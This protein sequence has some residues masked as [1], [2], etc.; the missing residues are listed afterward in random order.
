LQSGLVHLGRAMLPGFLRTSGS[1]FELDAAISL[2]P[3]EHLFAQTSRPRAVLAMR[4]FAADAL[5]ACF[6][7]GVESLPERVCGYGCPAPRFRCAGFGDSFL[8]TFSFL[9]PLL[10]TFS[11]LFPFFPPSF[12]SPCPASPS[13]LFLPSS[14]F[15]SGSF[16]FPSLLFLG[17]LFRVAL[18]LLRDSLAPAPPAAAAN[19]ASSL[20]SDGCPS[21]AWWGADRQR[22]SVASRTVRLKRS[23]AIRRRR[24]A[25]A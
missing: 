10:P 24:C 17:F 22:P 8:P 18:T 11:F 9:S 5:V 3:Q 1:R 20:L 16:S 13:A 6:R 2:R 25:L 19:R 12:P 4:C 23:R 21:T 7:P 14:P 15:F